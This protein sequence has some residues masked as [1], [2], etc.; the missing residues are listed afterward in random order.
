MAWIVPQPVLEPWTG[1]LSPTAIGAIASL[2]R[3]LSLGSSYSYR[4]D[5]RQTFFVRFTGVPN[6]QS[7]Y[8]DTL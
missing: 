3:I 1:R 4:D 5:R 2:M 8:N 7:I 6:T